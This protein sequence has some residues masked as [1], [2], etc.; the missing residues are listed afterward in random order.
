VKEVIVKT[1]GKTYSIYIESG[2]FQK[3]PDIFKRKY[4]GKKLAVVSDNNVFSIYGDTFVK[5]LQQKGFFVIPIIFEAGEKN[6]N[7]TTLS[8]IYD[9]L[10]DHAFTRSDIV[11]ALGGGVTGDMAGLAAAT[12]L[13]GM[14][15]IQIPS[16][17]LAMVDSSIGGKT[18]VDLPQGKNLIGAF[19]QPDAV[20]TD[21]ILLETLSDR[22]FSDGMAELIKHGIIR[23]ADLYNQLA[24]DEYDRKYISKNLDD[25]IFASCN[26]KK[27]IVEE[28]EKDNG[29]RQLLNFGHT[30]G[31]A[32]ERVLNYSVLSHGEAVSIGM[33]YITKLTES[34]GFTEKGEA[35]KIINVLKK[36]KLPTQW[37]DINISDVIKAISLDKKNRSGKITI[38]CI[39][40]IGQGRLIEMDLNELE[41]KINGILKD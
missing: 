27:N 36:Y 21:P 11:V 8:N 2:I 3:L 16:T 19:Y 28:D 25:F 10:A 31:H 40:R 5:D 13:R 34:I 41:D 9:A 22:W 6:K 7:L 38:A 18:A 32:I 35:E 33:V 30:I 20:Y 15:F 12:F 24:F 4:S 23:D 39:E 37:P 1:R 26:I 14:G 17:L 29:I